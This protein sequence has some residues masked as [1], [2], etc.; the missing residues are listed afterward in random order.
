[1]TAVSGAPPVGSG[2]GFSVR[3]QYADLS[4]A[5]ELAPAHFR[6]RLHPLLPKMG[7]QVVIGE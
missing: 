2:R 5:F 6:Y 1:M 4:V 7:E 3:S